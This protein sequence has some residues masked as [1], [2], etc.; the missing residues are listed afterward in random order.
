MSSPTI[1]SGQQSFCDA[2]KDGV[3][4]VVTDLGIPTPTV[5]I[6]PLV[7]STP[8]AP[9]ERDAKIPARFNYAGPLTGEFLWLVDKPVALRLAQLLMS[10]PADANAEF[11]GAHADAFAE[12]TRRAA[13]QAAAIW[14][15][16]FGQEVEFA[17]QPP[18]PP[19]EAVWPQSAALQ[20][21]GEGLVGISAT[22]LLAPKLL[23]SLEGFKVDTP[24][25]PSQSVAP[26][27]S[28]DANGSE[29]PPNNLDLLLDV[30]LEATIRFGEREL[31]LREIFA[32]MPGSLVELNQLVNEPAELLIAGRTIARGEVVVVDGN[33]G[34]RVSEVASR[35]QRAAVL[36]E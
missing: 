22:L 15:Q 5:V 16:R 35:S 26:L 32:L 1:A 17:F 25:A 4:G 19:P 12:F 29:G 30:E 27:P 34:L 3:A 23:E 11:T 2:W 24:A 20:L 21:S 13:G 36:Q 18:P 6:G 9:E 28:R 8:L 7:A 14:K 33:F 31:L 10:E